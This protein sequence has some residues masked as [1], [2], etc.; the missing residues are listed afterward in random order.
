MIHANDDEGQREALRRRYGAEPAGLDDVVLLVPEEYVEE[1]QAQYPG[2][3]VRPL[4]F[5]ASELKIAHWKFLMGAVG[6]QAGYIR[7]IGRIIKANR[8]D[9]TLD[10]VRRGVE[11]STLEE[12]L[13]RKARERLDI[14]GDYIDDSA[15]IKDLVRPGRLIVVDLRSDDIEKSDAL[16]LFVVPDALVLGGDRSGAVV[17]QAGCLR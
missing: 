13:K 5:A 9:L 7:Q 16:S 3:L 1:R 14:A 11:A 6:N 8:A 4:A 12:H 2:V 10:A 17:Q 15:R